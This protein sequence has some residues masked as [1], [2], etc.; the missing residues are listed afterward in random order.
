MDDRLQLVTK[1]LFSALINID[2]PTS[3][4]WVDA[5]CIRQADDEEKSWQVQQMREIYQQAEYTMAWLGPQTEDCNIL[6]SRILEHTDA[7][8]HAALVAAA[9]FENQAMPFVE[10]FY[11]ISKLEYLGRVWI[12]Q[13]QHSSKNVHFHWGRKSFPRRALVLFCDHMYLIMMS[14]FISTSRTGMEMIMSHESNIFVVANM[15]MMDFL[16][17]VSSKRNMLD[18]LRHT[19]A[20]TVHAT[21]LRDRIYAFLGMVSDASDLAIEVDYQKNW[22]HVFANFA[23]ALYQQNGLQVFKLCCISE[24]TVMDPELPSWVPDLNRA[25]LTSMSTSFDEFSASGNSKAA[26]EFLPGP[27]LFPELSVSGVHVDVISSTSTENNVQPLLKSIP[28]QLSKLEELA[29]KCTGKYG[30][31]ESLTSAVYRVPVADH[32]VDSGSSVAFGMFE[33]AKAPSDG[34]LENIY[35]YVRGGGRISTNRNS[36]LETQVDADVDAELVAAYIG[37]LEGITFRRKY[38]TTESGYLGLG[39]GATKSGDHVIVI[40]GLR[41]P[42]ILRP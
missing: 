3:K 15:V 7:L 37:V 24:S 36:E 33:F 23:M 31:R 5:I 11:A 21:D 27:G 40:F 18:L 29:L 8:R 39:P 13:E 14:D 32:V 42:Y 26:F 9:N 4:I 20:I 35:K 2:V 22:R 1:N 30:S 12:Q 38:F 19:S 28:D 6:V 16:F 41:T 10:Q 25:G 34:I 17:R